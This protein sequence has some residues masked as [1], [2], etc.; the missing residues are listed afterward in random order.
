LRSP[1]AVFKSNAVKSFKFI[2]LFAGIGGFHHALKGLGG[3]CVLTCEIDPECAQVYQAIFPESRK[4]GRFV[5]N[6]RT[7]TRNDINDPDSCKPAEEI[8][9]LVP[10]HDV[11]CA[12]FPCQ[13]FSKSGQ[14]KGFKDTT[15]GTLFFDIMEIVR[16]RRPRFLFLENVRNLAGPRHRETWATIRDT[17]RLEGYVT[18]DEPI[19]LSPHVL[20]PQDGGA[21]QVRERVFILASLIPADLERIKSLAEDVVSGDVSNGWDPHNWNIADILLPDSDID[22]VNRYRLSSDEKSWVEAW[23]WFVRNVPDDNLPGFPIW[24]QDFKSAP[25]IPKGC[26]A[27]KENFLRKNSAFYVKHKSL[28][29]R[30]KKMRWGKSQK[31][32]EEF[33]PSRQMFEWQAK[34][35]HPHQA[36]RKL[37]D[38]VLQFRPSGIRVKPPSYLPALVAITQTSV[39][40]P[41]VCNG[42]SDY[43]ELTPAEAAKLQGMPADIF[44]KAK[45]PDRA[46]YKQLGNA[47][48]VG[49]I[50]YI[51]KRLIQGGGGRP[52]QATFL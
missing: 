23:D 39:V 16:A 52:K 49:V 42:I 37:A 17:I 6:I 26:P 38:L 44:T 24:S 5:T 20:G 48:N 25:V 8:K 27:W 3:K 34:R 14:Q 15:R 43:R 10:A 4:K 22:D 13:P 18:L 33:P 7:I 12:G 9:E 28:I 45:V 30:W 47:V 19:V 35:H 32:V 21:P 11:L 31:T 41:D 50:R 51:G 36:G 1:P 2:D 46:A 29:D 40:G